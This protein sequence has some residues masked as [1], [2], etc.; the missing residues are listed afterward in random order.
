MLNETTEC[1]GGLDAGDQQHGENEEDISFKTRV[2]L[3]AAILSSE[4]L[5]AFNITMVRVE[6]SAHFSSLLAPP[7][8]F[9]ALTHLMR[10]HHSFTW[11]LFRRDAP[12]CVVCVMVRQDIG[13]R[14][15]CDFWYVPLGDF[16][17]PPACTVQS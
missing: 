12:C 14:A 2:W 4:L 11:T 8:L 1:Q 3:T 5:L 17:P 16:L 15:R 9:V 6:G 7:C 13:Y 10:F